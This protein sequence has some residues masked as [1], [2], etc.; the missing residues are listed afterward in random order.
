MDFGGDSTASL[1]IELFRGSLNGKDI[2]QPI[3][4]TRNKGAMMKKQLVF[5]KDGN[6]YL[7][8]G[9]SQSAFSK[10]RLADRLG[11]RGI[12]AERT[13]ND[14]KEAWAY[15]KWAFSGTK[16]SDT[17]VL[18]EGFLFSGLP[19]S[20]FFD[21]DDNEKTFLAGARVCSAMEAAMSQGLTL[22]RV[23]AGGIFISADFGRILFLP[24]LL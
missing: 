11:E 1:K 4:Y 19:L 2:I 18:L 15:S 14:G 17:A 7:D 13:E 24:E 5:S 6:L 21:K 22:P 16:L 3:Y 20:D 12:K 8:T 10:T 23:G 9:M